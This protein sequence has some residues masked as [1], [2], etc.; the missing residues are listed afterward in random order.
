MPTEATACPPQP[1]GMQEAG[2]GAPVSQHRAVSSVEEHS[3]SVFSS[4]GLRG[5]PNPAPSGMTNSQQGASAAEEPV[6]V[7]P[8]QLVPPLSPGCA[9][10][11]L[12]PSTPSSVGFSDTR[13]D[14]IRRITA[15]RH[16]CAARR[17]VCQATRSK[18]QDAACLS[19][20]PATSMPSNV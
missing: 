9:S 7:P 14:G 12:V 18:S 11:G 4:A 16:Y 20:A 1:S 17:T 19:T 5:K 13:A 2:T 3:S 6:H 10:L 15:P 8:P